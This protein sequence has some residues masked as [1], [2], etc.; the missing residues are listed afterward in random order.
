MMKMKL[1]LSIFYIIFVW[2]IP[3]LADESWPWQTPNT[4]DRAVILLMGDTNI[5]NR[6]SHSEGYRTVRNT[7]GEADLRFA[8]LEGPF[9]GTSKD[10]R[11]KDI[12]HKKWTHSEPDQVQTLVDGG[13]DV[14]GVANNVTWP[15][16][17]LMRSI[18]VLDGAGIQH[19]GGGE[20]IEKAN[21]PVIVEVDGIKV[22]FLSFAATVF[23]F[24][25]AATEIRPGIAEIKV[26][27]A[28]QPP[29]N[30]DKPAQPPI[31]FTWFDEA[32]RDRMVGHVA[33]L[34][35]K[36]DLVITSFH[37][38]VSNTTNV[39]SYQRD[40]A[41]AVIDAGA[42]VVFGHGPHRYQSIEV[43]KRRPVFYSTGQF[44]F[45]DPLRKERHREGLLVRV[46]AENQKLHSVSF[47]PTWRPDDGLQI[48]LEDPN[49]G[50]GKELMGYLKSVLDDFGAELAVVG[51]EVQLQGVGVH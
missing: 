17:A 23:P 33:A 30:L 49:R 50:Q 37:W 19:V 8:N 15:W 32:S 45:D 9:A 44:L 26:H 18:E 22:G 13:I 29:P 11:L 43:Y 10:P 5:Q 28:Y 27:T 40:I 1:P 47:V 46:I 39:V 2:N 35:G 14:V 31:V 16:Q 24:E 20:N 34:K 3:L 25:H 7:L 42:D 6:T 41:H 36:T 48:F 12:P 21:T 51:K 38:G 4:S